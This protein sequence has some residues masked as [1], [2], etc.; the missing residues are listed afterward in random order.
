MTL[1]Q[2]SGI[3]DGKP[4][5]S[6]T[7]CRGIVLDFTN[8]DLDYFGA[9]KNGKIFLVAPLSFTPTLPGM[10]ICDGFEYEIKGIKTYRNL[11]GD[12][13]LLPDKAVGKTFHQSFHAK[14]IDSPY[15]CKH[16]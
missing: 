15:F 10:M 8:S 16:L 2:M 7:S 12:A 6:D 13:S 3:V 4:T 14:V 5:W 1:R 9:I 11:R